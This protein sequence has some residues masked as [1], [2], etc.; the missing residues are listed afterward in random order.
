MIVFINHCPYIESPTCVLTAKNVSMFPEMTFFNE[1]NE[2]GFRKCG[3][4][5]VGG[6][7]VLEPINSPLF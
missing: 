5:V 4:L 1:F 6:I 3:R 2:K 7:F